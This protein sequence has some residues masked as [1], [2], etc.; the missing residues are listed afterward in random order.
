MCRRSRHCLHQQRPHLLATLPCRRGHGRGSGLRLGGDLA[1]AVKR[2]SATAVMYW[3]RAS[4]NT[5]W[6]MRKALDVTRTNNQGTRRLLRRTAEH[7]AEV[8]RE[9]EWTEAERLQRREQAER[10]D[11]GH[12]LREGFHC[13]FGWKPAELKLLGKLSDAEIARYTGRTVEAVRVKRGKLSCP[14][15]SR[16]HERRTSWPCSGNSPT[17]RSPD[18]PCGASVRWR[19]SDGN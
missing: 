5:V 17:P 1:K 12:H 16:P 13:A 9:R 15:R 19:G 18:E 10:L 11:L 14:I 8:M 2:E 3:W 7:V 4:R 6:H